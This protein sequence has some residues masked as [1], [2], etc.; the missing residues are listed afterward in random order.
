MNPVVLPHPDEGK[1]PDTDMVHDDTTTL[2]RTMIRA[3][4]YTLIAMTWANALHFGAYELARSAIAALFTS[5]ATFASTYTSA[6]TTTTTT[7]AYVTSSTIMTLAIGCVS[8]CSILL[9]TVHRSIFDCSGPQLSLRYTTL[10]YAI[11]LSCAAVLLRYGAII[12]MATATD[13]DDD[14]DETTNHQPRYLA[15]VTI[16]LI[17]IIKNSFVQLLASQHWSFITGI[18]TTTTIP[19]TTS[20]IA[21]SSNESSSNHTNNSSSSNRSNKHS[22]ITLP[23]LDS[24]RWTTMIAG[25][26]SVV[27]TLCGWMVAPLLQYFH[28]GGD[29]LHRNTSL[30]T[31]TTHSTT[32]TTHTTD[33]HHGL[34]ALLICAAGIMILATICSDEAYRVAHKVQ[35]DASCCFIIYV[36]C[37][38][39]KHTSNDSHQPLSLSLFL[40]FFLSFSVYL[41][42]YHFAPTGKS[43]KH[44]SSSSSSITTSL[45]R[46]AQ[47]LFRHVPILYLLCYEVLLSQGVST[48]ISYMFITYTK[49]SIPRDDERASHTGKVYGRIN[50]MSGVLQFAILPY[51]FGRRHRDGHPHTPN[52][53]QHGT[54]VRHSKQPFAVNGYWLLLPSLLGLAGIVMIIVG[55]P[56]PDTG[57]SRTGTITRFDIVT[58]SFSTMK[59][60][61]YSLRVALVERVR[62]WVDNMQSRLLFGYNETKRTQTL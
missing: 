28:N 6:S 7:P 21:T 16:I 17:F 27:A 35:Q 44:M 60:L 32:P 13:N 45:Y 20:A 19:T 14:D 39:M 38:Y 31:V 30:Q 41:K 50:F 58:I 37:I 48:L 59:L 34:T 3:R 52:G 47:H 57:T 53:G 5:T 54:D 29:I 49:Q 46:R 36:L 33:A 55:D 12:P 11:S 1:E 25:V 62:T 4:W 51:L 2:K 43:N 8:P 23:T 40:S 42:K 22:I 10:M 9:L 18:V 61:E 26:G 15:Q 56:K 24:D